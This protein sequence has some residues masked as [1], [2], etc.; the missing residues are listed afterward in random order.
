MVDIIYRTANHTYKHSFSTLWQLLFTDKLTIH[1]MVV[2]LFSKNTQTI[3]HHY[4][5][6]CFALAIII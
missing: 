3:E 2:I 6:I 1:Y 5:S 4:S